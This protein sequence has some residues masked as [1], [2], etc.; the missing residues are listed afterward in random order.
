METTL[1]F[2]RVAIVGSGLIGGSFGLALRKRFPELGVSAF[3][4]EPV[5][6]SAVALGAAHDGTVTLVEAVR[7]ADLVYVALPIGAAIQ[8]LPA[9]AAVAP[10]DALVTDVSS[11]KAIV[12][13][14]ATQYFQT[15]ARFLGGHPMAGKEVSGIQNADAEIF[16]GAPYALIGSESDPDPRVRNF[17]ELLRQ[18]G[19]KPVWCDAETHDWAVSI[20]SH[21]PQIVAL[22]LARLVSDETDETGM[23]LALAG[24]G[25]QDMLR[26]AASP[27]GLWRDIFMAN[28]ENV[29]HA[30][31]RLVQALDHVRTSLSGRELEDEFRAANQLFK[32]LR[33][34]Q[35]KT[36]G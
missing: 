34:E 32:S 13:N 1:P 24:K 15:G 7:R 25:L 35:Q 18:M 6:R 5:I 2:R 29:S 16:A 30:L 22:A 4:R 3:D 27:Y 33:K 17:V 9:I 14:R 19:A 23:P 36:E 8:A 31:D 12:C 11:A 26:L 10:Q 20:V 21:L 28:K